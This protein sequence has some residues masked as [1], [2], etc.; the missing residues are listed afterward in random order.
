MFAEFELEIHEI[1]ER[2]EVLTG[3][4]LNEL[5]LRLLRSYH[6]HDEGVVQIADEYAVEWACVPHFYYNFYVYQ[7]ATGIVAASALA[8][9]VL[10]GAAGA[11]D[12]YS[13]FLG[14][15]GADYP[16]QLLRDAGVDLEQAAPYDGAFAAIEE[17]LDQLEEA[18]DA[19]RA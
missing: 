4:R 9:A 18:L 12:R 1:A 3:E 14:S 19:A 15:G 7:Y 17:R 16:L 13:G 5:Y 10:G 6:G 2:D 8:R 11:T